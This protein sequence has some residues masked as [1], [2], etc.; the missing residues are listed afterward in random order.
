VSQPNEIIKEL[1]RDAT[2]RDGVSVRDDY[3]VSRRP[4]T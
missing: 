4:C 3:Q 2:R 1:A